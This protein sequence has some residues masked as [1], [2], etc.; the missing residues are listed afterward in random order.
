VVGQAV[1][2]KDFTTFPGYNETFFVTAVNGVNSVDIG[3][4]FLGV[5]ST[6]TM[7]AKSLDQTDNRVS[8]RNNPDQPESMSQAE[9]RTSSTLDLVPTSGSF[10]PVVDDTP[11][12]GDFIQDVATERFTVDTSTGIVTYTGDAP[13]SATISFNLTVIKS[14]GG[15]TDTATITLFQNT[16]QQTKTDQLT[17]GYT[18]ATAQSVVYS[19]GLFVINTGDTFDLRINTSSNDPITI[20]GVTVLISQQ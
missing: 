7:S 4:G 3:V 15:G 19:G 14:S 18:T 20:S 17:G 11:V 8:A 13:L 5:D 6:G 12:A 1:V 9:G 2:L 16:T 10:V